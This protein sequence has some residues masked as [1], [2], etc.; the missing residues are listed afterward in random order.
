MKYLFS[1]FVVSLMLMIAGCSDTGTEL[2]PV[3]PKLEESPNLS[4]QTV[5]FN[6]SMNGYVNIGG[7]ASCG[8]G[9]TAITLEAEG[10]VLHCGR[11]TLYGENCSQATSTQGGIVENG[12]GKI[13]AADG[14][15]IY[16]TYSG[17]YVFDTYPPTTATFSINGTIVGGTGTFEGATG[18]IE[19][20][21]VEDFT[22]GPPWSAT[23]NWT[24]TIKY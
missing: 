7:S 4:K 9:W 23:L 10:E 22:T 3:A 21:A 6:A 5:P 24:G 19:V 20:E 13:T 16:I 8:S 15:T 18:S 14:D 11:S 1:L 12:F 17:T 2:T